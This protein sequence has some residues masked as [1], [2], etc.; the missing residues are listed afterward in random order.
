MRKV[1]LRSDSGWFEWA[2][3]RVADAAH[4]GQL[5]KSGA[6][7]IEHVRRVALRG[8]HPSERIV[9][10]L[11]DVVEDTGTTFEQ[12][13]TVFPARYIDAVRAITHQPGESREDYYDRVQSSEIAWRV[14]L[15][16][17]ADNTDPRRLLLLDLDERERLLR[18][19]AKALDALPPPERRRPGDSSWRRDLC[20]GVG[21][22]PTALTR[23]PPLARGTC[24][25]CGKAVAVRRGKCQQHK[26]TS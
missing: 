15:N 22:P 13:A 16:D 26:A 11:H 25:A 17:I 2:A 8:N 14:K 12:L 20:A 4:E 18:K 1:D 6:P 21:Q 9:G 24:P 5:D 19:Y 3:E 10:W 7:Y 23:Q